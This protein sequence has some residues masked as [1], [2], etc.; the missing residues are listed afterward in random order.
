MDDFEIQNFVENLLVMKKIIIITFKTLLKMLLNIGY[1][2]NLF[3]IEKLRKQFFIIFALHVC[4]SL[5]I[6]RICFEG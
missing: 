2:V 3:Q 6:Y 5:L 4:F 1:N